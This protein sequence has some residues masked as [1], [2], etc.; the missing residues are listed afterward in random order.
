MKKARCSRLSKRLSTLIELWHTENNSSKKR[1]Y[2]TE[3]MRFVLKYDYGHSLFVINFQKVRMSLWKQ[4]QDEAI[5][6]HII[7]ETK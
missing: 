2:K 3:L 1:F 7:G 6:R 4:V 5:K